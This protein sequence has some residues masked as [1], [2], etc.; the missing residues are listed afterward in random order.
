LT[1]TSLS[2]TD[3]HTPIADFFFAKGN[4]ESDAKKWTS[5]TTCTGSWETVTTTVEISGGAL[6]NKYEATDPFIPDRGAWFNGRTDFMTIDGIQLADT[7]F[8]GMWA[9]PI[10]SGTLFS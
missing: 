7:W 6:D 1:A 5:E 10:G 8:M 9:R 4:T 3:A 2:V